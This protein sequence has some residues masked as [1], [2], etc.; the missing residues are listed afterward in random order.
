[1]TLLLGMILHMEMSVQAVEWPSIEQ[2]TYQSTLGENDRVVLISLEEYKNLEDVRNASKNAAEWHT[3][4]TQTL[5]VPNSHVVLLENANAS[6]SKILAS[7][8]KSAKKLSKKGKLW[9]V[10]IGHGITTFDTE[11][12]A[13]LPY[14][15]ENTAKDF[16]KSSISMTEIATATKPALE[17]SVFIFDCSFN[18]LD[19]YGN[20]LSDNFPKQ[21]GV[22]PFIDPA[23]TVLS[24]GKSGEYAPLLEDNFR[25]AFSFLLL[26]GLRGW[27]DFDKNGWVT[28]TEATD[29]ADIVLQEQSTSI[30]GRL[31]KQKINEAKE[32]GP[33]LV[34]ERIASNAQDPMASLEG[35]VSNSVSL[36]A[37]LKE[38]SQQ[39]SYEMIIEK[40]IADQ[41]SGI[42]Q[43]A[44]KHW[45]QVKSFAEQR[46]DDPARVAVYAFV[47]KY[48]DTTVEVQGK[49]YEVEIPEVGLA[50]KLLARLST[51]KIQGVEFTWIRPGSFVM[52]NSTEEAGPPHLVKISK[53]FY[54]SK[55]EVTQD[56]YQFI[57]NENPSAVQGELYPV[58]NVSW[59]DAVK[60]ANAL[61]V[62]EGLEDCYTISND[63]VTMPM[64]T[65][66]LGYRLP[67]EAE[68]E[69]AAK[70]GNNFVYAGGDKVKKLAW[71]AENSGNEI[72]FVGLKVPNA[73]GLHDMSGN[74][75]EWVWD[76]YASYDISDTS[77]PL[78][79]ISG[80]YRVR[81]GGSA[82]DPVE[83]MR[84]DYRNQGAGNYKSPYQSFRLVRTVPDL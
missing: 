51:P 82:T 33:S 75:W 29:Y 14:Y 55:T 61:S 48:E 39:R 12:A 57:V 53:S 84:I 15:T 67:T 13:I 31:R 19:R 2:S 11:Q 7:L 60:F 3:Y 69:Y 5:G 36:D 79:A 74:A 1:M 41:V 42:R 65:D 26:G 70:A 4:F 40:E 44:T 34:R 21:E 22:V 37:L 72:Q 28:L 46:T 83:M 18:G 68:W 76:R 63:Q 58:T 50:Y 35:M 25:P 8:E 62:Y 9:V 66:C 43:E 52:G 16:Y 81:R 6:R 80:E 77:N 71:S 23:S 24:V 20:A 47:R 73:W 30:Q 49:T 56:L 64:G 45:L 10:Y 54:M 59:L 17:S 32:E 27:A 38:L 78:G